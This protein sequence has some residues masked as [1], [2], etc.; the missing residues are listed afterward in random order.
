M[1]ST[2]AQSIRG[3]RVHIGLRPSGEPVYTG[4]RRGLRVR[5]VTNTF[6]LLDNRPP[7]RSTVRHGADKWLL[8]IVAYEWPGKEITEFGRADLASM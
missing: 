2:E 8:A 6:A 4:D 7:T 3:L 5:Y 1:D